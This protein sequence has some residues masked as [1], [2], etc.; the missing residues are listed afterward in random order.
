MGFSEQVPLKFMLGWF[1][2][3]VITYS[4]CGFLYSTTYDNSLPE[5]EE[6]PE[7]ILDVITRGIG[8]IFDFMIGIFRVIFF[9]LPEI[10]I[11]ITLI[12]NVI[13]QPFNIIF[14]LGLYPIIADFIDKVIKV[15]DAITPFT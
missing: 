10:P 11:E 2:I 12:M 3:M 4:V 1:L 8:W 15:I 14:I 5:I 9:V 6:P 7:G 13:I